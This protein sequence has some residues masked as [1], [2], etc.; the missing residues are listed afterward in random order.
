[1]RFKYTLFRCTAAAAAIVVSVPTTAQLPTPAEQPASTGQHAVLLTT[2]ALMG[3]LT[4]GVIQAVRGRSFLHGFAHG[5]LGGGI[6]YGGKRLSAQEFDGAG[7]VGRQVASIGSSIA[8]NGAA[9][10]GMLDRVVLSLGPLP[11]RL[12]ISRGESFKVRPIIDLVSAGALAYGLIASNEKLDLGESFSNGVAVFRGQ[13]LGVGIV[14][15]ISSTGFI[16]GATTVGGAIFVDDAVIDPTHILAHERVHVLQF[17]Y[18]QALW[19]DE[20]DSFLLD[21]RPASQYLKMNILPTVVGLIGQTMVAAGNRE[22]LPWEVEAR[23]L[24]GR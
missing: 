5:A 23:W 18:T 9:G 1:M 19:G 17:D 14:T 4:S 12:A 21:H 13:S 15:R 16:R 8:A 3:G 2:N 22:N 11:G 7:L 20:L 24:S 10:R 6:V